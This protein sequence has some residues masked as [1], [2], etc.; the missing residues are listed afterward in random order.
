MDK[1]HDNIKIYTDQTGNP[2][3]M[4]TQVHGQRIIPYDTFDIKDNEYS[5]IR[6]SPSVNGLIYL[7]ILC[8]AGPH[9]AQYYTIP[10]SEIEKYEV[11]ELQEVLDAYQH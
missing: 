6:I 8:I 1:I 2:F 11:H 5:I 10:V 7:K 3:L 9:F 4:H